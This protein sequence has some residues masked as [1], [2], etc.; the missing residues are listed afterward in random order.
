MRERKFTF[1]ENCR[2]EINKRHVRQN[3]KNCPLCEI[4]KF[5]IKTLSRYKRHQKR[6][7]YLR[8]PVI[9]YKWNCGL[10]LVL[11]GAKLEVLHAAILDVRDVL[12]F[13]KLFRAL[14]REFL[15][16]WIASKKSIMSFLEFFR[17]LHDVR[18]SQ[19][20]TSTCDVRTCMSDVRRFL[21]RKYANAY[22]PRCYIFAWDPHSKKRPR[23]SA[24]LTITH[25]WTAPLEK[26]E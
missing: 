18:T 14:N 13:R 10:R 12:A 11:V 5:F 3:P 7:H 16:F 26:M 8:F 21:D 15:N 19:N 2:C 9:R 20:H 6:Q 22:V 1:H 17:N 23:R 24:R 4:D 25:C